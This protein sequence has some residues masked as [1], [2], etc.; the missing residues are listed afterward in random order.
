MKQTKAEESAK[1]FA[2]D[3]M[4]VKGISEG[5]F[6]LENGRLVTGIK[7]SP[8]NIFI[9]DYESQNNL[10]FN[11]RSFYDRITYEFWLIVIYRPV[12]ISQYVSRLEMQFNEVQNLGIRKLISEDI[13]KAEMFMSREINVVDTEYYILFQEKKPDVIAKRR[14][15]LISSLAECGIN[16]APTTNEDL[17]GF[18]D[19]FFNGNVETNFG[20]VIVNE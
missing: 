5:C 12:D 7:I 3:W 20:T 13:R 11:L 19:S 16:A 6:Q 9:L 8:K 17:R 1:K 14:Q 15:E 10:I 2:E 4:P 18:L